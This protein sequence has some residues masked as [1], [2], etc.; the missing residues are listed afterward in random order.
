[1]PRV[2]EG[3]YQLTGMDMVALERMT[4]GMV[5]WRDK[6]RKTLVVGMTQL[7]MEK[8]GTEAVDLLLEHVEAAV[9]SHIQL[10][11]KQYM[12]HIGVTLL[13][14]SK[15]SMLIILSTVINT[16]ASC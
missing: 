10:Q 3:T 16:L 15:I 6:V 5:Q 2:H 4:V 9:Q 14:N 12:Q 1:M 7:D 13:Q 11:H 8:L